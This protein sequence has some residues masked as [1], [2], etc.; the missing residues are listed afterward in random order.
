M[1]YSKFELKRA[2]HL[3]RTKLVK[4]KTE[5]SKRLVW[6]ERRLEELDKAD[7]LLEGME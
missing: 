2:V 3:E 1:K 4:E 7:N 6:I 5:L